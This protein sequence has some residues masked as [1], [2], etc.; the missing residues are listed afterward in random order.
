[1]DSTETLDLNDQ[2]SAGDNQ[3][4]TQTFEV[5]GEMLTLEELQKGYLRQSDYTR[6]AQELAR[7]KASLQSKP[8]GDLT[9]DELA[10]QFIAQK[11]YVKKSDLQA[12]IDARLARE[13]ESSK[14]E[15]LIDMNPTLKQHETAIR[16]IAEVDDSAIEDIIVKYN[17]L[18]SDKLSKAKQRDVVGSGKGDDKQVDIANMTLEQ[19][20]AWKAK[21]GVGQS[22]NFSRGRSI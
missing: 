1:M 12:E 9:E 7:E 17:F 22:T 5:N 18:S 3:E 20:A 2:T 14:L 16:K 10:D 13:R 15:K 4:N 19:Y 21:N 6:K 8:Q 11:G